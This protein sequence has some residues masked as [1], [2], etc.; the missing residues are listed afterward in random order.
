[1]VQMTHSFSRLAGA[2]VVVASLLTGGCSQVVGYEPPAFTASAGAPYTLDSGDKLKITVFGQP[3]LSSNFE[4]DANGLI[5]MPLIGGVEARNRTTNELQGMIE[6]RLRN[7]FLREPNVT[8][9][10]DT[11]RPFFIL[12]E[13]QT[14]GQYPYVAN[15]TAEKAVAIANG[16][17][18][19]AVQTSVEIARKIRGTLVRAVVPLNTPVKPGDVI[20]VRERW[21]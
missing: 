20:T 13:V 19:R 14:S 12:G 2:F 18:P 7:G 11:Y 16:F 5:T 4:V 6:T 9:A 8:V 15:M 17:S 1:M 10:V 21:F 3:S